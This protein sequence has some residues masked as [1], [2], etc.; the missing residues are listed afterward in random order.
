MPDIDARGTVRDGGP[1]GEVLW[2]TGE[3]AEIDLFAAQL[4][5]HADRTLPIAARDAG[6]ALPAGPGAP[7]QKIPAGYAVLRAR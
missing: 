2:E 6:H 1:Q 5:Q 3:P 4:R 7:L